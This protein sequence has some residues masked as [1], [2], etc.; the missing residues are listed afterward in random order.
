MKKK[1]FLFSLL[2][3]LGLSGCAS[4]GITE[5]DAYAVATNAALGTPP[6]PQHQRAAAALLSITLTPTSNGDE[7][8]VDIAATMIYDNMASGMTQQ[9]MERELAQQKAAATATAV[10]IQ[11][12]AQRREELNAQATQ[13]AR[14]AATAY[15]QNQFATATQQ[16]YFI[17]ATASKD[18]WI[19][20]AAATE[21]SWQITATVD[22]QLLAL[23][24]QS[25]A[26]AQAAEA[27]RLEGESRQIELAVERQRIKNK[28][29]AILPWTLVIAALIV[30]GGMAYSS[31]KYREA[32]RNPDGTF[33]LPMFRTEKG[34][35]LFRP[36]LLP[37]PAATVGDDGVIEYQAPDDREEQA[38]VTRR[39]Q[40]VDA[41]RALPPGREKQALQITDGAFG[42]GQGI[43]DARVEILPPGSGPA[44][45][46]DVNPVLDEL[47]GQVLDE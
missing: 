30:A 35:S 6:P 19:A 31:S 26:T 44:A 10:S 5:E 11:A 27:I 47:E 41:L 17:E 46:G 4:Y 34:W 25:M 18:A 16:A 22:A 24:L 38:E 23:E 28:A 3:I 37:M 13:G 2:F 42:S 20:E 8:T 32:K 14:E 1:L 36:E 12:T 29:D 21:R 7:R 43:A 40:A 9:A 39:N 45:L 33:N 15:A